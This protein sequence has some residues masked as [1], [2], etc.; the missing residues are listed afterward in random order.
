[1]ASKQSKKPLKKPVAPRPSSSILLLSPSNKILLLHRVTTSTSFASAHVFPGG[2]L[3]SFHDGAHPPLDSPTIHSDS[4]SYRLAAIRET[5]EESG[6]LLA[7]S[8]DTT[9][10]ALPE[11]ALSTGRKAVHANQ[12]PFP[13]WLTS[14]NGIPDT[15]GLVPFTRWITPPNM[16][17]RF[18][19]QMYLYFMD[20]EAAVSHDGGLEHT[21]VAWDTAQGWLDKAK[22]GEVVLFPPQVYLIS[23]VGMFCK[24]GEVEE[25]REALRGFL[26]EV[27]KGRVPWTE[28]VIS[29][30]GLGMRGE[31]V[32]LG[33]DK[34]G[35]E[36]E[37]SGRGGDPE[38]V[39]LVKFGKE[40]PSG[41][42]V[43]GREEVL[44]EK[45]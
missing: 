29:P 3:S 22:R 5:F 11:E 21:E 32:V 33:L 44:R 42:E 36:L 37:G 17:K 28:K 9:P 18:T 12:V 45:L 34:P 15:R 41:V 39:V 23:I 4:P 30:M 43:K 2:N 19:T 35:P 16:P 20:R 13:T 26:R 24:G 27:P 6:I 40:G 38:R 8:P 7:H 1:M 25:E 10:L 14:H 31:R